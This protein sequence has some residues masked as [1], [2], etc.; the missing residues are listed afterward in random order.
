MLQT[1][2]PPFA[3][4]GCQIWP[5]FNIYFHLI[6]FLLVTFTFDK[7][8]PQLNNN[9]TEIPS[10]SHEIR[11]CNFIT[12]PTQSCKITTQHD[13]SKKFSSC[14]L[15]P[16]LTNSTQPLLSLTHY[17]TILVYLY[18]QTICRS[19][20]THFEREKVLFIK[21]WIKFKCIQIQL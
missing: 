3:I 9:Q 16:V 4:S 5:E 7:I 11:D 14:Q 10:D 17:N 6:S 18:V 20:L 2:F 19:L 1:T 21:F 8:Q 15:L 12:L 13:S